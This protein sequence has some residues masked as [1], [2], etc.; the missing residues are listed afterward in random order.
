MAKNN[1]VIDLVA[2]IELTETEVFDNLNK[3]LEL[4]G[5]NVSEENDNNISKR[6]LE[7]TISKEALVKFLVKKFR[8][9]ERDIHYNNFFIR[10]R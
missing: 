5:D 6:L 8:D 7:T 9:N 4:Y 10:R 3:I 1:I 2:K